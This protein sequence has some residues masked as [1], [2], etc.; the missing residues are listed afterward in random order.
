MSQELGER[1]GMLNDV[2]FKHFQRGAGDKNA[3]HIADLCQKITSQK[4]AKEKRCWECVIETFSKGCG[5]GKRHRLCLNHAFSK[6]CEYTV[7]MVMAL[8]PI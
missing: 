2:Q 3:L 5:E 8:F 4:F 7:I 6:G 1:I